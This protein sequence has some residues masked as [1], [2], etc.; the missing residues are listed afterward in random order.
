MST[1]NRKKT[2]IDKAI[3]V[4]KQ[5]GLRLSLEEVAGK[6]GITKKTL[7]NNF[8]S[9]EEL[10][11]ACILSISSDMQEAMSGLDDPAHSAIE[12]LR[13]GFV[14][15]NH[16]FYALSPIFFYD[17][18]RM[19]PNE[20]TAEHLV[21]SGLFQAKMEA[22]LRKGISEGIYMHS[23]NV[24]YLSSYISYSVFGFYINSIIKRNPYLPKSHFEDAVEYHLRAIVSE[25]GRELL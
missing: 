7:Y 8:T 25:R 2:Y 18:M 13:T 21:G 23:I 24:E 14:K 19:S 12:N 22:N 9:K 10:V 4:F 16:F 1:D 6:M 20:A 3:N 17:I 15:L 11:K 5:E